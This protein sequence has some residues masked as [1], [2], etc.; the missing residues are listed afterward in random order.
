M[1]SISPIATANKIVDH[2]RIRLSSLTRREKHV[3]FAIVTAVNVA[4][5]FT[6]WELYATY[7]GVPTLF[8]PKF[9]A[10]VAEVPM[11]HAEGILLPNFWISLKN[12]ATGLTIGVA[13]G[14]PLAYAIGGIKILDRIL[15]PYLWALFSTPR[16]LLVPLIFLWVGIGNNARLAIVIITV[17][18]SL[19]VVVMEG[20]KTTDPTMI[21]A[22]RVFGAN[23][24]RLITHVV[25]PSTV[26]FIGTGLRMAMLR[27][28][29][30]LYI[31]ELFLTAN[32]IGYIIMRASSIFDT[33]RVFATLLLFVAFA[34]SGLFVTRYVE[35]KL[36]A[37]RAPVK[38]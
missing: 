36:T 14:L 12:Y 26:P 9:S 28:L 6:F 29:I 38:L 34:I 25:L 8:L 33:A 22:A 35:G 10:V 2:V 30:G 16:I 32:G 21:R 3:L 19:A 18:P 24:M 11:M 27:G 20:V 15:S 5:F 1:R 7:S 4:S 13:L 17:I 37:W 23:R 31:G